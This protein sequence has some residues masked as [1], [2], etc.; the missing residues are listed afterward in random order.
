MMQHNT[1]HIKENK[2]NPIWNFFSSVKLTV[3]LL[4]ILAVASIV[5]T[6]IPQR[7]E[8]MEFA[9]NL[10]PE[11]LRLFTALDIFNMYHSFWFRLLIGSLTLNLI[12]CSIDRFPRTLRRVRA[13][14]R[15][16]RSKP[17]ENLPAQQTL[18]VQGDLEEVTDKI[19][20]FLKSRYKRIT[21]K[22]TP[23]SHF[24]YGEKGRYS[25]FGVYLVH[26]SILTILVGAL[27][28]SLL[29][30]EAYVNIP[31]GEKVDTVTLRK[32]R[33]PLKL[34]FEV[35]CDKFTV[36]FYENRTPKEYR[37]ELSF[38]LNG[39]SMDKRIL[40]VNHPAQ[41]LG[42]TFYQSSYGSVPG[43][44]IRL[45]ISRPASVPEITSLEVEPQNLSMLPGNEGQFQVAEVRANFMG[46][47]PAVLISIQPNQGEETRFWVFKNHETITQRFPRLIQEFPKMNPS[48][49]KPYTFFL[50]EL[51]MKSYTGL[52]V[53]RDPGVS[54]VWAGCFIMVAGFFLT[55]FTSHR[56][57]WFRISKEKRGV[58]IS[59]AGT[60]SKNPVGFQR[61][62]EGITS[63]LRNIFSKK[64]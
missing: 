30:F 8:A 56:R 15:A 63:D 47:G 1:E 17:F 9:R 62:L 12:I 53:N 13:F 28:G 37:S 11:M 31:E 54:I 50:D 48:I 61:E 23:R 57:L 49:F 34:G 44:K 43:K 64:G 27:V 39:K 2:P 59:V 18:L 36:D 58:E 42:V 14:P 19:S 4:I 32:G 22:A 6:F 3:V 35:R 16:D 20:K 51:E 10:S 46:L 40:L 25:H 38:L 45:K 41:F 5:G 7:E 29:G 33:R 21:S 55:F 60:A 52:Q 24:I 26:L